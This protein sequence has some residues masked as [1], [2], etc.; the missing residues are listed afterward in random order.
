MKDPKRIPAILD[1]ISKI[2]SNHPDLRLGQLI[3]NAGKY[4]SC[5]T[6][7]FYIEDAELVEGLVNL[8]DEFSDF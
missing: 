1:K 2:W 5:K 7:L 4:S 6:D 3:C 8:N